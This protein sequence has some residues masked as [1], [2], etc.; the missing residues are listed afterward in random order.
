MSLKNKKRNKPYHPFIFGI[1]ILSLILLMTLTTFANG[2]KKTPFTLSEAVKIALE[3]GNDM[4]TALFELKKSE[5]TYQ[6]TKADLLLNP[7]IFQ[8][9]NSPFRNIQ[10]SSTI[11][12]FPA[13]W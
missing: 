11:I 8:L 2:T 12:S 4:K 9:P 3:N 5:L 1:V 10:S 13:I 7:S 6:Q